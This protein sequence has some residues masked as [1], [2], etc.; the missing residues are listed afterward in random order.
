MSDPCKSYNL[1]P[2]PSTEVGKTTVTQPHVFEDDLC[3]FDFKIGPGLLVTE[4]GVGPILSSKVHLGFQNFGLTGYWDHYF[5]QKDEEPGRNYF[6]AQ[7]N[8]SF[9]WY[10]K[11]LWTQHA[12]HVSTDQEGW[13]HR[14]RLGVPLGATNIDKRGTNFHYG[15]SLDYSTA[16]IAWP[17]VETPLNLGLKFIATEMG[18][19]T[20]FSGI[21]TLDVGVL[22][23][24]VAL[25][26]GGNYYNSFSSL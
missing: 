12:D 20:D 18:D 17:T 13:Y 23:G 4:T 15:V 25:A 9:R 24:I 10:P 8:Y 16:P 26:T 7:P 2:S 5:P 22:W 6:G 11:Y 3:Q 1:Y 21:F 19:K 14:L